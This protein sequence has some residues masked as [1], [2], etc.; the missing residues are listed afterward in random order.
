MQ[1]AGCSFSNL[2]WILILCLL[3]QEFYSGKMHKNCH[4]VLHISG[5]WWQVLHQTLLDSEFLHLWQSLAMV[6]INCDSPMFWIAV[7]L[8]P[9]LH[10][11]KNL[12]V[13]MGVIWYPLILW[14]TVCLSLSTHHLQ[15]VHFTKRFPLFYKMSSQFKHNMFVLNFANCSRPFVF[16]VLWVKVLLHN[17]WS[18]PT[19]SCSLW[20]NGLRQT[21]A[22]SVLWMM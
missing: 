2:F 7:N 22:G 17:C 21:C 16:F 11:S 13:L 1:T 6:G 5:V 20:H 12:T 10:S 15:F 4:C 14:I 3:A 9:I 8:P 19:A 18:A